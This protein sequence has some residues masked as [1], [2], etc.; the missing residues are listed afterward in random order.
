VLPHQGKN[1][2]LFSS[3]AF[4]AG[5]FLLALAPVFR[6]GNRHLPLI[7]LE[8][9]GLLV[10]WLLV[11]PW[12]IRRSVSVQGQKNQQVVHLSLGEWVLMLSPLWAALLFLTPLPMAM[13]SV[14]PGHKIYL[15]A[16][17]ADWQPL[18]LTPDATIA[19]LLAGVPVVAAFVFSRTAHPAL[20][21]LL[22]PSLVLMAL[23]QAIWGLL[24]AGLFHE[25]YFGA[26][27]SGALIGSFANSNHFA[28]YIAMTLP[29]AMFLLWRAISRLHRGQSQRSSVAALLWA[30]T[31]LMLLA[32]VLAS[33]S[34]TGAV[35]T[36]MVLLLAV[37]LLLDKLSASSRRWYGLG[38][39][40][41][42]L[43]VLLIVSVNSLME[44]LDIDRLDQDASIRWQLLGSS[45]QA[46]LAFWP[47]GAGPG[48]FSAVYPQFQPP[49]LL[50]FIEHAH[51][52]YVQFLMEF[53]ALFVMLAGLAVWLFVRQGLI[54]WRQAHQARLASHGLERAQLQLC[55]ALG[56]LALLLHS[57]V[58]FNLRIPA[59]AMLSACL[60]GAFLRPAECQ[61]SAT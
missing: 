17:D 36:L 6:G 15:H 44:R 20:F 56:L 11:T 3:M 41:L 4:G 51:N 38:A 48:S 1:L 59:N 50:D 33:G 35:T 27:F 55:C 23:L 26:E 49:G 53:G 13:W 61:D 28:N 12:L 58:D 21:H 32:A 29:L 24:Q 30:L 43:A 37:L 57:W 54:L 9:M 14:L 25:L 16:L 19:S 45:W 31:L 39:G 5:L 40:V 7:G 52:D 34:R 42:L 22:P 2:G 10:L 60:L 8:W 46:A 18:S 47:L